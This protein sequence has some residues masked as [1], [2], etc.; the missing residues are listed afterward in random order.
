MFDHFW[1][2]LTWTQWISVEGRTLTDKIWLNSH[3]G[4]YQGNNLHT[5]KGE[6]KPW[7]WELFILKP[8]VQPCVILRIQVSHPEFEN[9]S[10]AAQ[11]IAFERYDIS[12]WQYIFIVWVQLKWSIQVFQLQQKIP[13]ISLMYLTRAKRHCTKNNY[14]VKLREWNLTSWTRW[15]SKSDMNCC[16]G[17]TLSGRI[18]IQGTNVNNKE[19]SKPNRPGFY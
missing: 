11:Y 10:A 7:N 4:T 2:W 1:V 3:I 9:S 14:E 18:D 6:R 15:A 19:K 13:S 5:E 12:V 8:S 16:D 17:V